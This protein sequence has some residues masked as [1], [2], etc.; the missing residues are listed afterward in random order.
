MTPYGLS[1]SAL[2]SQLL[3]VLKFQEDTE[4]VRFL[5]EINLKSYVSGKLWKFVT[6]QLF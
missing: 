3:S 1:G 4:K 6:K 2:T 5:G